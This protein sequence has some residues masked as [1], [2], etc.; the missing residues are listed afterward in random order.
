MTEIDGAVRSAVVRATVR[1]PRTVAAV[2]P[3]AVLLFDEIGS[4][5]TFAREALADGRL[6]AGCDRADD[7]ATDGR[8]AVGVIA[9]VATDTQTAGRGRLDHTWVSKAG[10]SFTVSFV[11]RVPR[12]IATNAQ[13]NGW[14]QMIAGLSARDALREVVRSCEPIAVTDDGR[15]VDADRAAG[16]GAGC[17]NASETAGRADEYGTE[18]AGWSDVGASRSGGLFDFQLK[19]PNDIFCDGRKLGGILAEMVILPDDPQSVGVVFG[20]GLNL[21][22]PADRLPTEQATSLQ[23]HYRIDD[24]TDGL[25]DAIAAR[26]ASS[27]QSRLRTFAD[28]PN[29]SAATLL[30]ETRDCCWTLGRQVEAH[31][32][33]G[34]TLRGA[35]LALNPDASLTIRDAD[36]NAHIVHT[37]D[38]GV[39]A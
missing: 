6:T 25:R 28:D 27:L 31:F 3:G 26:I 11:T 9:A 36:G 1:M 18:A 16:C 15:M 12:T 38:V 29:G 35:A 8:Q 30:E 20:V 32:T 10:E 33:D 4:T 19:W 37:A 7:G 17:D 5:N 24:D 13:I 14:L 34:S 23:L 22:V 21:A 39:L 2:A